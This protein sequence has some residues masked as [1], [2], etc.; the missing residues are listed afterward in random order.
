[1]KLGWWYQVRDDRSAIVKQASML[2][3]ALGASTYG[4]VLSG[5]EDVP[6]KFSNAF[7]RTSPS[8]RDRATSEAVHCNSGSSGGKCNSGSGV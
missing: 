4:E 3:I 6:F 5:Y 2:C 8:E 1:M 7:E